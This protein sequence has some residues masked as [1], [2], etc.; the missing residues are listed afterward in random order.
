MMM[1]MVVGSLVEFGREEGGEDKRC[2]SHDVVLLL[3]LRS[4]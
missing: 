2:R 3:G 4:E 1:M